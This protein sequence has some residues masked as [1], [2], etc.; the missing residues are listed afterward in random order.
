MER[1]KSH[2]FL[3]HPFVSK[4]WYL[5]L[6]LFVYG[7]V[8]HLV[9]LNRLWQFEI[10]YFDHA[11][12]DSALWNV[13]HFRPPFIDHLN[14]IPLNQLGDHFNP[15]FYLLAPLYWITSSYEALFVIGNICVMLSAFVMIIIAD[16]RKI[17]RLMTTA[18]IVAYTLFIGLQNTV[19]AGFHPELP[20]LLTLSLTLLFLEKKKWLLYGVFL[21][22]TLGL[23][24][25]FITMGV[26]LGI[27]LL[28]LK[29]WKIGLTT[30]IFSGFYYLFAVR[31]AIPFFSG[32]PYWYTPNQYP[33]FEF[34]RQFFYPAIKTQ[35]LFLSF[36]TFG[37]LPLTNLFFLPVIIQDYVLRF[38][39]SNSSARIDLG[40]HY[41]A[42]VS[43]LLMYAGITGSAILMKK[44][45]WYRSV[46]PFHAVLILIIAVAFHYKLHGPL[47]LAYNPAFYS[48]TKNLDFLRRFLAAVPT[49]GLTMT[50]NNL[51]PQ[52]THTHNV[53]L[54]R[55]DYW[56]YMP[57]TIAI[58][59]RP[60]Q[61]ANNYWPVTTGLFPEMET[62]LKSDP[63]YRMV[64]VTDT[65]L[66][67]LKRDKLD[68]EWYNQFKVKS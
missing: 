20:A 10:Y 61:S 4:W 23:K 16:I 25:N 19:I 35:T 33:L 7:I 6:Y 14:Q 30:M 29:E 22:L 18:L 57:D 17:P 45:R 58:D 44:F 64:P 55:N 48:H 40:M 31:I 37:F 46:V 24:E 49:S 9:T 51:A 21:F 3:L 34:I 68:M 56:N 65:Q 63:N 66:L 50:Q 11:I 60:G 47:G 2:F 13:A 62:H 5:I 15:T 39:L 38:V 1:M 12:F 42:I 53:I 26:F 28:F 67:F 41:N 27:Y 59:V 36:A 54:L 32:V 43:V 8:I 52:L